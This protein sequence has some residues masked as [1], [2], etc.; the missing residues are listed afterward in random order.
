MAQLKL[1][2]VVESLRGGIGDLVFKSVNGRAYVARKSG[3]TPKP[4]TTAQQQQR[5]EFTLATAYGKAVLAD[6]QAHADYKSVAAAKGIPT[7]S[8]AVGDYMNAPKVH[9]IDL[10]QYNRQTGDKIYVRATD[11]LEVTA[12]EVTI[13]NGQVVESGAAVKSGDA[14]GRWVYTATAN[15]DPGATLTVEATATGR[16]GNKGTKTETVQ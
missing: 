9:E 5:D 7:Y 1:H 10:S 13:R 15:V 12:V 11:E 14:L 2:A 4:P 6:P 16:P 8:F 3:K